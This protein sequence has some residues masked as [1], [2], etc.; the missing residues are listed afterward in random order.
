VPLKTFSGESAS[1]DDLL[2]VRLDLLNTNQTKKVEYYSWAGTDFSLG[3]D[4]ATLKDNFGNRYKRV[5]FGLG[6]H[7]VGAVE[8]SDSL[9][10]NKPLTD[11]LVFEAPL[12]AATYLD[13]ELPAKNYGGEGM[14]RFRIPMKSISRAK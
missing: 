10:P 2:I 7:P 4:Y 12:D 3:R 14:I 6:T 9:Y 1:K 5:G 8:G 11:V 13:L